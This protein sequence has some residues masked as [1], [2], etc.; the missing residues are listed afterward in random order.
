MWLAHM[1]I[2]TGA[3]RPWHAWRSENSTGCQLSPF[4][5][6]ETLLLTTVYSRLTDLW[7]SRG[8]VSA[9]HL[10]KGTMG[11]QMHSFASI[12]YMVRCL[13]DK[14]FRPS[15]GHVR[16]IVLYGLYF[17]CRLQLIL[18]TA[19][20]SVRSRLQPWGEG[21]RVKMSY[22]Y[23]WLWLCFMRAGSG[24]RVKFCYLVSK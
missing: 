8:S 14:H 20:H 2:R 22:K 11:W 24:F 16:N 12:F 6:V 17:P 15:P 23:S 21:R 18:T 13:C 10:T 19:I 9:S 7:L 1:C 5:F 4:Y 3:H